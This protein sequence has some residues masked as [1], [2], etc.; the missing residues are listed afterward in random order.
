MKRLLLALILL[1][2][3]TFGI[4]AWYS[5]HRAAVARAERWQVQREENA[6]E[7]LLDQPIRL[8]GTQITLDNVRE[9]IA[10]ETGL[11]VTIDE[12]KIPGTWRRR[13]PLRAT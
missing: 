2:A 5:T 7:A 10:V 13:F 1:F 11:E 6:A 12:E 4:G 9:L 3:A 8:Y